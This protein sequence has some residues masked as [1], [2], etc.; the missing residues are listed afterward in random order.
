MRTPHGHWV[1]SFPRESLLNAVGQGRTGLDLVLPL[2]SIEI[3]WL[4]SRHPSGGELDQ[5][6]HWPVN[7]QGVGAVQG[8]GGGGADTWGGASQCSS[9]GAKR[10]GRPGD[11]ALGQHLGGPGFCLHVL[12]CGQMPTEK[13]LKGGGVYFGSQFEE[14]QQGGRVTDQ[15]TSTV[16]KQRTDRKWAKL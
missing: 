10:E 7:M 11:I 3:S 16:R 2:P 14:V 4:V 1:C 5:L 8:R 12:F 6:C 13:S 15:T 9:A